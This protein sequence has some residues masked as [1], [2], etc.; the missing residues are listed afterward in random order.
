MAIS[1]AVWLALAGGLGTLARAGVAAMAVRWCGRGLPWG[2]VAVN[3]LGSFVFGLIMAVGRGRLGLP[4]GLETVLLV[5]FLGGFTTYSSFAFQSYDL[6]EQG[7]L[8]AAAA[9]VLGTTFAAL[10]AVGAGLLLGR[11]LGG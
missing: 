1:H 3:V 7:R 8:L 4:M 10:A 5:G 9:Y 11:S 2:T 6:L